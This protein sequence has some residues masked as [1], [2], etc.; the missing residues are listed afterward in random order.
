LKPAETAA[1]QGKFWGMYD[2]LFKHE[3]VVTEDI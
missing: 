3:Q 2:Y 1:A